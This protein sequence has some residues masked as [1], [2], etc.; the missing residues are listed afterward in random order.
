MSELLK[1]KKNQKVIT[2]I[3]AMIIVIKVIIEVMVYS[4]KLH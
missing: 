2:I 1:I 4:F 3:I